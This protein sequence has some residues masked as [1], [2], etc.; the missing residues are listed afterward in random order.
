MHHLTSEKLGFIG[1]GLMG[2]PMARN[3]KKA[4]AQVT[5]FNRSR[6]ALDELA[7]EGFATAES[8]A[9]AAASSDL[10]VCMVS[11]TPAVESVLFGSR[12]VAQGIRPGALVIDMG[13]TEVEATR[14]F[15]RR[16]SELSAAFVDAPVSGGEIGAV[17]ATLSIMVGASE[18]D[19][20]RVE[21]V[22]NAVGSQITHIGGVGCGQIAKAANQIIVGLTIGA[23]AEAFALAQCGGAD[24]N[25]VWQALSGGFASS[26]ILELHGRRMIEGRFQPG[27]TARTQRKDLRQAL[28]FA[29]AN[30]TELPATQL[31]HDRYDELVQQGGGALDHSALFRL[32]SNR[33]T[34]S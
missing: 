10:T 9:E 3:L 31:C 22:L 2:K 25:Q 15:A 17:E 27:G 19:L 26:K 30:G 24:L 11:D 28:D 32:Y 33:L 6:P 20:K 18:A 13:T 14:K 23:V 5:V 12:G 29:A 34:K 4:G 8:A 7:A 1:L 21:P 16:L